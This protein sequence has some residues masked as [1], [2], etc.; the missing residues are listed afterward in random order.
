LQ[1][2]AVDLG[3]RLDNTLTLEAPADHESRTAEQIVSLQEEMQRRIASLPGIETV[4]VGLAVPLR[5]SQLGLEIKA[6]GPPPEPGVPVP[7][8]QYR[9]ATPEHFD[10]A[11]LKILIG[12]GFTATDHGGAGRVAIL[13]Q[14]LAKRLFGD[15][16]P[17]GRRVSWTGQVLS[18]IGMQEDWKTVVGVVSNARDDGP[19]APPPLV[20]YQPLAQNDLGYFPGA[21]V[22]RGPTAPTQAAQVQQIIT[23]LAPEQPI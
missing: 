6:E 20:L 19:D 18:A 17:I 8:A 22:I 12:R 14:A 15:E 3:V 5:H 2:N 23:E 7:L 21:F 10:A 1:L 11:G 4:G 9:T 13:N 16:D